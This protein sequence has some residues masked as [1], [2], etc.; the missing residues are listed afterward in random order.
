[1]FTASDVSIRAVLRGILVRNRVDLNMINIGAFRGVIRLQGK[2]RR[3]RGGSDFT[4]EA[5]ENL[6]RDVR[7]IRGVRRVYMDF[8]NWHRDQR[9]G[10]WERQEQTESHLECLPTESDLDLGES[11]T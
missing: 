2:I 5:L 9:S 1:M 8:N 6:E 7:F 10:C 4:A 11:S 3:T